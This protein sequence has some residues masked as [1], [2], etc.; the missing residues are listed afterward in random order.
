MQG[1]LSLCVL[2]NT[3]QMPLRAFW[4]SEKQRAIFEIFAV[5]QD[6]LRYYWA[7]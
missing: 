3:V 1:S 7:K 4:K 6:M 5:L 2:F